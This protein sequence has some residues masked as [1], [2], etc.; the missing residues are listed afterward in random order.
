V[1][2]TID[3]GSTGKMTQA[4]SVVELKA[5]IRLLDEQLR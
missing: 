5:S 4:D 2:H 3:V 1:G